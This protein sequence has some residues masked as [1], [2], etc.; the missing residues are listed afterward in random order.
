MGEC[1]RTE[2]GASLY[3]ERFKPQPNIQKW[4]DNRDQWK[5]YTPGEFGD[6]HVEPLQCYKVKKCPLKSDCKS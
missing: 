2:N 1:S 6:P 5:G 3:S 4:I